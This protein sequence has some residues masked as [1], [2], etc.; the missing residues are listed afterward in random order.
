MPKILC[1]TSP[2]RGR[3]SSPGRAVRDGAVLWR[4]PSS[5]QRPRAPQLWSPNYFVCYFLNDK[6]K[7]CES[8]LLWDKSNA[9]LISSVWFKRSDWTLTFCERGTV[10]LAKWWF[11]FFPLEAGF[12]HDF[13]FCEVC[14]MNL[15]DVKAN[16]CISLYKQLEQRTLVMTDMQEK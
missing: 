3:A 9:H 1:E 16:E 12:L 13:I 15:A 2:R 10:Y 11:F 14:L 5:V 4:T 7:N 6:T 8:V